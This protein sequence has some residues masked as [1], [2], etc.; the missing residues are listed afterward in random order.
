M[1]KLGIFRHIRT[2]RFDHKAFKDAIAVTTDD[3]MFAVLT[4][5]GI[6]WHDASY[7][8]PRGL[9]NDAGTIELGNNAL[10]QI[11]N[12]LIERDIDNLPL[13]RLMALNDS[14]GHTQRCMNARKGVAH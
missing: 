6:R 13:T 12:G 14:Q 3:N 2:S 9:A 10:Q 1:L 5:I 7:R 4:H 8:C 11:K